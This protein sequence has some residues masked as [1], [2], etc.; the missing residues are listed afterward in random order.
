VTEPEL[1]QF[2]FFVTGR[3]FTVSGEDAWALDDRLNETHERGVAEDPPV[4]FDGVEV[5]DC[6]EVASF[7]H[8]PPEL[9]LVP[10]FVQAMLETL[11]DEFV[12]ERPAFAALR[13]ALVDVPQDAAPS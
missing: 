13:D 8:R 7:G 12:R 5:A 11:T 10:R 4:S 2:T 3:A 1:E 9:E 6:I